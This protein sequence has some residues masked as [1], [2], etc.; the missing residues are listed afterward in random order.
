MSPRCNKYNDNAVA[1]VEGN[2]PSSECF[3][4]SA[5]E[6]NPLNSISVKECQIFLSV[7]S[8]LRIKR[9]YFRDKAPGSFV[10]KCD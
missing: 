4:P 10:Q 8:P 3:Y 7:P 9:A 5:S 2:K 6:L 1:E